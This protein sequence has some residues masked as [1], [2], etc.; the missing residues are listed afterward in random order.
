MISYEKENSESEDEERMVRRQMPVEPSERKTSVKE[1]RD[2]FA[3]GR[4]LETVKR[5]EEEEEELSH[6]PED[7]RQFFRNTSVNNK[8]SFINEEE[9]AEI[10]SMVDRFKEEGKVEVVSENY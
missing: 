9:Q 8:E 1:L 6:I 10:S 4:I 5:K 3:R 7:L 2:K